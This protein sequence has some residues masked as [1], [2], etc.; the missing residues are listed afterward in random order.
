[1]LFPSTGRF[2]FRPSLGREWW[3]LA[4]ERLLPGFI[5]TMEERRASTVSEMRKWRLNMKMYISARMSLVTSR[6]S[7]NPVDAEASEVIE[8]MER[9]LPI[10]DILLF[11]TICDERIESEEAIR[12]DSTSETTPASPRGGF[13]SF[14]SSSSPTSLKPQRSSTE[15]AKGSPRHRR[16]TMRYRVS[17][18]S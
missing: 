9:R 16:F 11:R 2:A 15:G 1:M 10:N 6:R 4:F 7:G 17:N 18:S 14:F 8:N 5:K 3:E 13:G 12:K